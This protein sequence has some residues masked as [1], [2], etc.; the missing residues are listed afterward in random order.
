[1]KS[2]SIFLKNLK[3]IKRDGK[4]LFLIIIFP[5]LIML[6][7]STMFSGGLVDLESV[8]VGYINLDEGDYSNDL[9]NKIS[10]VDLNS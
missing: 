2:I 5:I 8:N 4:N 1:M 3:Q 6:I 7:Y 10:E 9:L